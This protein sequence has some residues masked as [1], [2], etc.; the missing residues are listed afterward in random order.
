MKRIILAVII[1]ILSQHLLSQVKYAPAWFGPNANPVPEF[2]DGRIPTQTMISW[3]GDY[4]Y[5][6]GDQTKNAYFKIEFPLLPERVSFKI[7]STFFENYSVSQD[8]FD[9]SPSR[10]HQE[11]PL[12][13]AIE[14]KPLLDEKSATGQQSAEGPGH[15]AQVQLWVDPLEVGKKRLTQEPEDFDETDNFWKLLEIFRRLT[16]N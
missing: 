5:G 4:Y 15:F 12:S 13:E 7:W 1:L 14:A 3:M 10:P 2:T 6:F 16:Q 9:H 8:V 11:G